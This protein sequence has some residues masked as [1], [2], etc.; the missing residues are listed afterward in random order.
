MSFLRTFKFNPD[1][2]EALAAKSWTEAVIRVLKKHKHFFQDHLCL[3]ILRKKIGIDYLTNQ[4]PA[5][6][7]QVL[8]HTCFQRVR[9]EIWATKQDFTSPHIFVPFFYVFFTN[10]IDK[11]EL[12]GLVRTHDRVTVL[13]RLKDVCESSDMLASSLKIQMFDMSNISVEEISLLKS[14]LTS[15]KNLRT[16]S[17]WKVCDDAMLEIIGLTCHHLSFLDIWKS[18]NVSDTGIR[19]LLGLDGEKPSRLCSSLKSVEIKDTSVTDKGAFQLMIHCQWMEVLEYSKNQF[20]HQL[21]VRIAKNLQMNET[22]FPLKSIF[23]KSSDIDILFGVIKSLP[24]LEELTVWTSAERLPLIKKDL[25]SNLYCLKMGGL[26]HE[27]FLKDFM[28]LLGDKITTLKLETIHFDININLVGETCKCLE[29]FSVIN[30]RVSVLQCK[31]DKEPFHKLKNLYFFLVNYVIKSQEQRTLG[32]PAPGVVNKPSSG[33]TALHF[34][35]TKGANLQFLQVTGSPAFTD[36]CLEQILK[37]NTLTKLQRFVISHPIGLESG[38]LV[39]P[40][41]LRSV[42]R[43]RDS[44][45]LLQCIGDL[46]HWAVTPAQRRKLSQSANRQKLCESLF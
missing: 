24:Y 6:L 15:V 39:V 22:T 11:V 32:P 37:K 28:F 31:V 21:L 12:P 25:L 4:V 1:K 7:L 8:F 44:C 3:R 41:T 40:L 14:V 35:L 42:T 38:K 10:S 43:L 9:Q 46:K 36:T 20:L 19:L 13:N 26:S 2:L 30:S 33:F 23:L 16:L 34:L 29:D 17:I 27:S 5:S 45:P 18:S